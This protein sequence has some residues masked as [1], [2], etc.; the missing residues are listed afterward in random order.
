MVA[1]LLGKQQDEYAGKYSRHHGQIA[2]SPDLKQLA[3][4]P[5]TAPS[6]IGIFAL[7]TET[8]IRTLYPPNTETTSGG[9]VYSPD[10]KWIAC[11]GD[12]LEDPG[13]EKEQMTVSLYDASTGRRNEKQQ[14]V[15]GRWTTCSFSAD[16]ELLVTTRLLWWTGQRYRYSAEAWNLKTMTRVRETELESARASSFRWESQRTTGV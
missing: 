12:Y 1:D 14:A 8:P 11:P 6:S 15:A 9:I 4:A 3:I 7:D 5:W 16:S 13:R 10:G 2:F